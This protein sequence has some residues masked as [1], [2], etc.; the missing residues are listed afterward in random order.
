MKNSSNHLVSYSNL[1]YTNNIITHQSITEYVFYLV[2]GLITYKLSFL[3][4]I[5]L[6]TT[7]SE[8][9]TL[10]MTAQKIM[11]IKSFLNHISYIRSKTVI[12]Y[13]NNQSTI[14]F[15]KNSEMHSYSKHI[16]IHFHWFHQIID[17]G[18]K[19]TWIESSN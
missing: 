12:M 18:I 2:R 9:M 6:S 13:E 14:D 11:W 4:I 19:I 8:Y 3:K 10:C 17:E 1:N 15:T 16:N 7:E 5:T